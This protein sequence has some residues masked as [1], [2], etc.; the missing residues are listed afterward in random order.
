MQNKRCAID[1]ETDRE[2]RGT[3]GA[4]TVSRFRT[5]CRAFLPWVAAAAMLFGG[6]LAAQAEPVTPESSQCTVS[7]KTVTCTG[8]LSGGVKVNSPDDTY[9]TLEVN[10]LNG[11]IAPEA[12]TSGINID[13]YKEATDTYGNTDITLTVD[14]GAN[15]ITTKGTN[16]R[17]ISARSAGDVTVTVTGK[18][19]AKGICHTSDNQEC[20]EGVYAR[21][22][23]DGDVTVNV[24]GD[25]E[26]EGDPDELSGLGTTSSAGIYANS[27]GAGG[28]DG[29]VTVTFRGNIKAKQRSR[30]IYANSDGAV[31]VNM[32]KGS[33]ITTEGISADGIYAKSNGDGDVMVTVDGNINTLG[34]GHSNGIAAESKGTGAVT[35]TVTGNIKTSGEYSEGI[36]ADSR[37]D[38]DVTV[39]MTGD[40]TTYGESSDGISADSRDDGDVTVTMTGDITTYGE[41]SDGISAD[42][43]GDVTVDLEGDITT[44]KKKSRGISAFIYD[45]NSAGNID[46]TVVTGAITTSGE[47]SAGIYAE[48]YGKGDVTVKMENGSTITTSGEKSAGIYAL[49]Y[50]NGAVTVNF[51]GDITTSGDN[52]TGIYAYSD[53]DSGTDNLNSSAVFTIDVTGDI[54]ASG[55]NSQGIYAQSNGAISITLHGGTITSV[56]DAGIEISGGAT[57]TLTIKGPVTVRGGKMI[58][59]SDGTLQRFDDVVGGSGDETIDNWGTLTTPGTINLISKDPDFVDVAG[60]Q[61]NVFNNHTGA[62]FNSGTAVVLGSD[63]EDLFSNAG[64]LSPGG[65]NAVQETTL[66]GNFQNYITNEQ[67]IEEKGTFTVTIDNTGSDRL[68]VT[69]TGTDPDTGTA[70]LRGTVRVRGA[71]RDS[72]RNEDGRY[73]ILSAT[74]GFTDTFEE[75]M[76]TLFIDYG[77]IYDSTNNNVDLS[78]ERKQGVPFSEFA[79]TANQWAVANALDSL[80]PANAAVG[81]VMAVTTP[82]GARAAYDA[83]SGEV[84]ASLKGMLMDAGQGT[85]ADVKSRMAARSGDPGAQASTAAFGTSSLAD[86]Q[87]GLWV[88]G[89]GASGETDATSGTARMETDRRGVVFGIDR[90][91]SEGWR[92][93]VLGGYSRTDVTQRARLSSGSVDTWSVGLYGGAEAGASRFSFGAVHSG[94]AVDTGRS[95]PSIGLSGIQNLSSSYDARSW[96]LFAEAGHEVQAGGMTLEPFAGVSSITLDT[97]GFSE[98]GGDTALAASSDTDSTMFATLGLRGAMQVDDTIHFRGMAGWRHAFGDTDPSSTFTMSGSP[99]FTVTGA[100]IAQDALDIELGIEAGL[101]DNAVLGLAYKGRYG[102][103]GANHGVNAGLRVRF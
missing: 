82:E 31:T 17:G 94:H 25:I 2:G 23:G 1:G 85:V 44:T 72:G 100:P 77:L 49:S 57:N 68:T 27:G 47:E 63:D 51:T 30:G 102:G 81:D 56:Q 76:D 22:E 58:R 73:T 35:V 45:E 62:T 5:V 24:T 80:T 10:T 39:T 16:A 20:S 4:V 42:S 15:G 59:L 87:S 33:N 74:G 53:N 21:S 19:T 86:G 7:D 11:D 50:G 60:E 97:D 32:K 101:S 93:G 61:T 69:R 46:I 96:Q 40:I 34:E 54:T 79:G 70:E 6:G 41:S 13:T 43:D 83:R 99:A 89:T 88:T 92:L 103:G 29:A 9:N 66:T 38:G 26:T 64:D 12:G 95:V 67:N 84:H 18:I 48:S 3:G 55:D 14:T 52:S 75:V 8:N 36:S 90:A 65:A 37:D 71:Y 78:S 91:L 28:D 98:S